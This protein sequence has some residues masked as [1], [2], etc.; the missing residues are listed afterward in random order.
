MK[1]SKNISNISSNYSIMPILLKDKV[2]IIQSMKN[3]QDNDRFYNP[4][5]ENFDIRLRVIKGFFLRKCLELEI[6]ECTYSISIAIFDA[7]I[8]QINFDNVSIFKIGQISLFLACKINE[9]KPISIQQMLIENN[10][11]QIK[12]SEVSKIEKIVLDLMKYR[13]NL[14][15]PF[16]FLLILTDIPGVQLQPSKNRQINPFPCIDFFSL[17]TSIYILSSFNYQVNQFNSLSVALAIIMITRKF[18]DAE[19]LLPPVLQNL[20]G[21][22]QSSLDP[23]FTYLTAIFLGNV[24]R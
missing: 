4:D 22:N 17:S 15:T 16:N 21:L 12:T 23:I 11:L 9:P 10:Q 2:W 1:I 8:S 6:S 18:C 5:F 7:V 13:L 24:T 19:V 20:T 3:R 14:V